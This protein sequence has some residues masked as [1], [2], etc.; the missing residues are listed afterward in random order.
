MLVVM[1]CVNVALQLQW[2]SVVIVH[3]Q[4]YNCPIL[5]LL[6][7]FG[8]FTFYS[9]GLL[10]EP[11]FASGTYVFLSHQFRHVTVCCGILQHHT[12]PR[13]TI[14]QCNAYGNA[15]GV[16]PMTCVHRRDKM[17]WIQCERTFRPP[18]LPDYPTNQKIVPT[19][20]VARSLTGGLVP[21]WPSLWTALPLNKCCTFTVA[22]LSNMCEASSRPVFRRR[23]ISNVFVVSNGSSTD[24]CVNTKPCAGSIIIP[25]QLEVP[26]SIKVVCLTHAT[27]ILILHKN[28]N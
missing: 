24:T 19:P 16:K 28:N 22:K 1:N 25:L 4:N 18:C 15:T 3:F 14:L 21:A 13:V 5:L 23:C 2:K 7:N 9:L 6:A 27:G 8:L 26:T 17:H 20:Q 10:Q 11:H 12:M